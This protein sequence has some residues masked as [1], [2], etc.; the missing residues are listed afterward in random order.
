[1]SSYPELR[2]KVAVVTGGS[3]GIGLETAARLAR[4][5][6]SVGIVARGARAVDDAVAWIEAAGG[7]RAV[8]VAAD[9]TSL[10]ATERIHERTESE[11]GGVDFLAAFAG[12]GTARPGPVQELS[13]D[14]WHSTV[15]GNLT[16]TFL[17]LKTFLPGMIERRAGSIVTM[18]SAAGRTPT[19]AAP[20]PYAAAKAGI[21]M[22]T[23]HVASQVGQYGV[24]VNCLSPS[25]VLTER[26]SQRM[27]EEVKQRLTALHPLGR[28]GEPLT[29]ADLSHLWGKP[30]RGSV[31]Y[32]GLAALPGMEQVRA[33]LDGRALAPPVARLTGRRIVDASSSRS[34]TR[35]RRRTGCWARRGSCTPGCSPSS[36]TERW[37]RPSSRRFPHASSARP[38]NP[39]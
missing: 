33:L 29:E 9:A 39:R 3:R 34:H 26:T 25:T 8:G 30:V 23:R 32:P 5:G 16:A 31:V 13:E 14:E 20:A 18:A 2:G 37:S 27:P 38:R 12:S 7:G 11:L 10:E 4:N 22:L 21:V 17:T 36:P 24:R 6:A 1:V 19:P 28:L 35:S 15:D